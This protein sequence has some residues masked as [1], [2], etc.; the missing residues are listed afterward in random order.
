MSNWFTALTGLP[1]DRGDTIRR[2]VRVEGETLVFPGGARLTAGRL[3]LP[4]LSDL[5]PPPV[6]PRRLML[7]EVVADIRA[8]HADR[9][10]E[11][12][13]FQV[14]SQFNLL[15][16]TGPEIT[17]EAGIARYA[18]DPTQGPACAMACAGGTIWRNDLVPLDGQIGQSAD[19]QIDTL[20]DL[21]AALG[22]AG[23]ALWAMRNGYALPR[24]GGLD[25]AAAAIAEG[26]LG[27]LAG[28][29]RVGVQADV[30][31][32]L[33]GAGHRVTQIYASA[34][35]LAYGTEPDSAWEP[36]A[37]LVLGAAYLATL[38]ATARAVAAGARPRLF[39]TRLG[40]GAFGN[41]ASWITAAIQSALQRWRAAPLEVLLVSHRTPDPANRPLLAAF[42]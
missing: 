31:V 32:T 29:L 23:G 35:P 22:N 42:G 28:L 34:M 3:D 13:V 30:G 37:R 4:R 36:L 5:P 38:A 15:E 33:P 14:A 24:P 41:P 2:L 10:N 8:L 40:G 7:R 1:D 21:G 12:A 11:G 25:R 39:L 16:M 9:G 20:A 18:L 27:A 19:R 6:G 17:P 26:D